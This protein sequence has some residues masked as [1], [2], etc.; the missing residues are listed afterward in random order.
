V[1]VPEGYRDRRPAGAQIHA[2]RRGAR[3]GAGVACGFGRPVAQVPV[4]IDAPALER[5]V[6]EY[7]AGVV[8]ARRD[9]H[10]RSTRAHVHAHRGAAGCGGAVAE[11]AT[12]VVAPAV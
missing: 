1:D 7:G 4:V 8:V 11:P 2:H 6:V 9:C 5:G 12:S 3:A 10:R